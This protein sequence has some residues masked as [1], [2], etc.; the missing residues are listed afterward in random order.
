MLFSSSS[1]LAS[2]SV[3]RSA[4][5]HSHKS[6]SATAERRE[7]GGL[8]FSLG[9]G[10]GVAAT[11]GALH[12]LVHRIA[13]FLSHSPLPASSSL[14]GAA[15][16]ASAYTAVA[17]HQASSI[18]NSTS[19]FLTSATAASTLASDSRILSILPSLA[20]STL[21]I[22]VSPLSVLLS[23][24]VLGLV[25]LYHI[26]NRPLLFTRPL[27]PE[28]R[29]SALRKSYTD[30]PPPFPNSWYKLCDDFDL[31]PS[32]PSVSVEAL[33]RLFNVRREADGCVVCVD[34][35]DGRLWETCEVNRVV[36][37]W[38]DEQGRSSAW[39]I[40]EAAPAAELAGWRFAGRTAHEIICHIQEIPEN[41]ADTAHLDYLHGDFIVDQ[42]AAAKHTW[43]ASWT[44]QPYPNT[45]IAK[46]SVDTAITLFGHRVPAS[47]VQTRINQV[48]PGVVQLLF[49]TPFGRVLIQDCITPVTSNIQRSSHV[50]YAEH[51]V[52]RFVSK[53]IFKGT[54]IQFERDFLV[55]NNK[56]WIRA[57]MAVKEDG[58]ILKY[59]RWMKQFYDREGG[60][61][62]RDY[63]GNER[64]L[65]RAGYEF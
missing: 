36:F 34:A 13:A 9:M 42:I 11:V 49:P 43:D 19:T 37:V 2:T 1:A 23:L 4:D 64:M 20:Q 54:L 50:M 7:S 24:L 21:P 65:E 18:V 55:W 28:Q 57:P 25:Y 30:M 26:V 31:A 33:G 10:L 44:P 60:Q 46:I 51:S 59:R 61:L 47:L 63:E 52:P 45:H 32:Q 38:Y 56:R 58:P 17:S 53:F 6:S 5:A 3:T 41:G 40:P 48:G 22:S 14:S 35:R 29:A 39:Q 12:P 16:T 27:E 62:L 15:I 8:S